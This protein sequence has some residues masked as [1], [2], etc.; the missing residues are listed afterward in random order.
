MLAAL[1]A[2]LAATFFAGSS[3]GNTFASAS[4]LA[5]FAYFIN[6]RKGN[7]I[8]LRVRV[9]S[10]AVRTIATSPRTLAV[11]PLAIFTSYAYLA[12]FRVMKKYTT[13][14]VGIVGTCE[15]A[16]LACWAVADG[17]KDEEFAHVA[18]FSWVSSWK[19][20]EMCWR[21]IRLV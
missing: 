20:D 3:L 15:D 7:G 12:S 17:L 19:I 2:S 9:I 5:S 6:V 16:L 14:R 13:S 4:G 11:L 18:G 10:R 21:I 8:I 1:L